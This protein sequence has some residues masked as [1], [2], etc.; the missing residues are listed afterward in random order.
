MILL[1]SINTI[2]NIEEKDIDIRDGKAIEDDNIIEEGTER[3]KRSKTY[4]L[5]IK[6]YVE[7]IEGLKKLKLSYI[8]Y[9]Y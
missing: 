4:N 6:K 8:K 5:H 3:T 9:D 2:F 7:W 1:L